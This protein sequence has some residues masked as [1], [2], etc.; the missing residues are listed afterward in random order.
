[1]AALKAVLLSSRLPSSLVVAVT[2]VRVMRPVLFIIWNLLAL[3]F[4][5]DIRDHPH[6][7]V[8]H[9]L[10]SM[11]VLARVQRVKSTFPML[12]D[13]LAHRPC[14]LRPLW[15]LTKRRKSCT[16]PRAS[17]TAT[18]SLL[19]MRLSLS[20]LPLIRPLFSKSVSTGLWAELKSL[21]R[22]H[23]H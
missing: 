8:F 10:L 16:K 12:L 18:S 9:P 15:L 23:L 22:L 3:L 5:L 4:R 14:K 21:E 19:L 7:R 11:A 1:M 20:M 17:G 13:S 6:P 2:V